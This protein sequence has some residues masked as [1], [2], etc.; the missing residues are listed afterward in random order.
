MGI[1]G[2]SFEGTFEDHKVELIRTNLDKK[3]VIQVDGYIVASESVALP[4]EWDKVKEFEI[5]SC[6]K[7]HR[8]HA[9][10]TVQK[11]L[12][13]IPVDN[14]YTIDIDGHEVFLKRTK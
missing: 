8:L 1:M 12:G 7:K 6:G 13:F 14:E 11:L 4:H 2:D 10:S 9:H 3:V 5:G